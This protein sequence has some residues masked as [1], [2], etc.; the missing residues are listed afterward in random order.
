MKK[1]ILCFLVATTICMNTVNVFGG[2]LFVDKVSVNAPQQIKNGVTFVPIRVISEQM[3]YEVTFDNTTKTINVGDVFTHKIGDTFI[4][5]TDGEIFDI[6]VPSYIDEGVAYMP[7]RLFSLA[8]DFDIQYDEQTKSIWIYTGKLDG[9]VT[10]LPE[11]SPTNIRAYSGKTLTINSE[12]VYAD[13]VNQTAINLKNNSVLDLN[14]ATVKKVSSAENKSEVGIN[15][16][17]IST[18]S[19]LNSNGTNITT[20]GNNATGIYANNSKINL[21]QSNISTSLI[22]S[23]AIDAQSNSIVN[24]VKTNINTA[25]TGSEAIN[26]VDSSASV[27]SGQ[28]IT[29]FSDLFN[30]NNSN[31]NVS[32]TTSN[33]VNGDILEIVNTSN[34]AFDKVDA[35][36]LNGNIANISGQGNV[37]INNSTVSASNDAFIV[38]GTDNKINLTNSTISAKTGNFFDVLNS[39][40]DIDL[41]KNVLTKSINFVN[42]ANNSLLNKTLTLKADGQIIDGNIILTEKTNA[43][44]KLINNSNFI[45]SI[46]TENIANEVIIDIDGISSWDVTANSYVDVINPT[47]KIYSNINSNGYNIYYDVNNEK[48]YWLER[49]QYKLNGGGKLVPL[50]K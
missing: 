27:D 16:A 25:E 39:D 11:R 34:V 44:I 43:N 8:F 47:S 42:F 14:S 37:T 13:Q 30:I 19:T 48:N 21:T 22:N 17:I 4:T 33:G 38:S 41:N 7:L 31:L 26:L 12:K 5:K 49:E 20:N 36:T 15:S 23:P 18:N 50:V 2:M 35:S 32:N 3:G 29:N 40:I 45:G 46:N 1:Y 6:G 10:S 24:L 9:L 28:I